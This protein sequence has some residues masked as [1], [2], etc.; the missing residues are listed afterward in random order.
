[1]GLKLK[2]LDRKFNLS[3]LKSPY[4]LYY[5]YPAGEEPKP[6]KYFRVKIHFPK[7][8]LAKTKPGEKMNLS[9]CFQYVCFKRLTY[10]I[11][12]IFSYKDLIASKDVYPENGKIITEYSR[13]SLVDCVV[14]LMQTT[15]IPTDSQAR[16][17][18]LGSSLEHHI[19]S[20]IMKI[21]KTM[22]DVEGEEV[23]HPLHEQQ[24]KKAA[25]LNKQTK[26]K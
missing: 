23:D 16:I 20:C 13:P 12:H 1:M 15:A 14:K 6:A 4:I 9:R 8:N 18:S 7:Q 5:G 26:K 19:P 2:C 22:S 10:N 21:K 17:H 11:C 3:A 25:K 24:A